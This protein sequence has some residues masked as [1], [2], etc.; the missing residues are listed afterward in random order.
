[1]SAATEARLIHM[2]NQIARNFAAEGEEAAIAATANHMKLFWDPRMKEA[3]LRCAHQDLGPIA[4]Q[5]VALLLGDSVSKQN[6]GA[7]GT[8]DEEI[9]YQ[10]PG[11]GE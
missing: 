8:G 11:S 7:R 2:A 4:R 10:A 9:S 6:A 3:I 5:A 1:M